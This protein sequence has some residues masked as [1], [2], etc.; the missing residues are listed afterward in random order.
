M[1][2]VELIDVDINADVT[3]LLRAPITSDCFLGGGTASA[4]STAPAPLLLPLL[5]HD[6]GG[7]VELWHFLQFIIFEAIAVQDTMSHDAFVLKVV[8][9]ARPRTNSFEL[10]LPF[11]WCKPVDF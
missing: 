4:T 6:R 1:K 11:D 3:A 10:T 9:L 2:R 7:Y 8:V 5:H